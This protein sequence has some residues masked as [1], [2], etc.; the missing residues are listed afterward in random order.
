MSAAYWPTEI[1]SSFVNWHQLLIGQVISAAH[2]PTIATCSLA[3]CCCQLLNGQPISAAHWSTDIC[4]SLSKWYQQLIGHLTTTVS[5]W[6]DIN[7]WAMSSWHQLAYEKL[8]LFGQ[9]SADISLP[10]RPENH[11]LRLE[12]FSALSHKWGTGTPFSSEIT[13]KHLIMDIF[14]NL[15]QECL[16]TWVTSWSLPPRLYPPSLVT[17]VVDRRPQSHLQPPVTS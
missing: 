4:C 2:C 8:T 7:T 16:K 10:I 15:I 12:N 1:R 6:A 5:Q 11:Q 14:F 9:W 13:N 17:L 3:N